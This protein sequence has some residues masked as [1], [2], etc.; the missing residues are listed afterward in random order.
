MQSVSASCRKSRRGFSLRARKRP[1]VVVP[2]GQDNK[3]VDAVLAALLPPL[4]RSYFSALCGEGR[5]SVDGLPAAKK[6]LKVAAGATLVVRL[7]AAAELTVSAEAIDLN[8]RQLVPRP[9]SLDLGVYGALPA[10]T[11]P[12]M[13]L[14][15][16]SCEPIV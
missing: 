11:P 9:G 4:S 15:L 16:D 8:V 3:R 6:S 5:V 7:R 2:E 10:H 1:S 12:K 13:P 14:S